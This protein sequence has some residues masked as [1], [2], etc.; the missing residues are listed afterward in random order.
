MSNCQQLARSNPQHACPL[1]AEMA[2]TTGLAAKC[3]GA[4]AKRSSCTAPGWVTSFGVCWPVA[5]LRGQVGTQ[6]EAG[7]WHSLA[8]GSSQGQAWTLRAIACNPQNEHIQGV[9]ETSECFNTEG[10]SLGWRAEESSF[11]SL[12]SFPY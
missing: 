1:Q 3:M 4:S 11:P 5:Q 2:D 12:H 8:S 6:S 10:L 9:R 7:L